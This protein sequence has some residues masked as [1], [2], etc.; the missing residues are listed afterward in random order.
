MIDLGGEEAPAGLEP[1]MPWA[2]GVDLAVG[3]IRRQM[4]DEAI[5]A[6]YHRADY[7]QSDVE[8]RVLMVDERVWHPTERLWSY[9]RRERSTGK[10]FRLSGHPLPDWWD[11]PQEEFEHV[12][13]RPSVWET[14]DSEERI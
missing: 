10:V 4:T 2:E 1:L 6:E 11:E 9:G 5:R 12:R 3:A 13:T 8:E 14:F 7:A